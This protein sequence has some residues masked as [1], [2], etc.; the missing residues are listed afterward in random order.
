MSP[1]IQSTVENAEK[2]KDTLMCLIKSRNILPKNI[3]KF[4]VTPNNNECGSESGGKK[5][6]WW[7]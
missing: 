7:I 1:R 3:C 6:K 5:Q 2:D 4:R